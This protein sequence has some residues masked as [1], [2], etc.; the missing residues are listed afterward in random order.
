MPM[1]DVLLPRPGIYSPASREGPH[2]ASEK[3]ALCVN[4][5]ELLLPR[6]LEAKQPWM[7]LEERD[8]RH[9]PLP[10]FLTSSSGFCPTPPSSCSSPNSGDSNLWPHTTHQIILWN[11]K[12]SCQESSLTQ[13]LQGSRLV[14][15]S[16]DVVWHH[17]NQDIMWTMLTG[18]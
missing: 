12:N 9:T 17:V 10:T 7:V 1:E 15:S 2:F 16:L 5:M 18:S 6:D 4:W 13:I 14:A 3:P 8:L 11:W